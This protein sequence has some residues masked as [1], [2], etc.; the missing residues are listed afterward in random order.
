MADITAKRGPIDPNDYVNNQGVATQG[1]VKGLDRD[2]RYAETQPSTWDSVMGGIKDVMKV[3]ESALNMA[4]SYKNLDVKDTQIKVAEEQIEASKLNR[5]KSE[6][7]MENIK[8][9][10]RMKS[11]SFDMALQEKKEENEYLNTVMEL[12]ANKDV[13]KLNQFMGEH[14]KLTVKKYSKLAGILL[15]NPSTILFISLSYIYSIPTV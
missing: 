1:Q 9:Q 11:I 14:A 4:N 7:E 12:A 10:M 6:L 5:Q 15:K 3:G 8:Q 13:D 2:I